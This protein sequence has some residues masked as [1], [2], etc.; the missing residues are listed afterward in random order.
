MFSLPPLLPSLILSTITFIITYLLVLLTELIHVMPLRKCVACNKLSI[1]PT[2][3]VIIMN[4]W[5]LVAKT[6]VK[7]RMGEKVSLTRSMGP[8][9][10]LPFGR[11]SLQ[12]LRDTQGQG[13]V[14]SWIH[15]S[16]LREGWTRGS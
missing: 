1:M 6:E 4:D 15:E 2:F 11:R 14:R 5:Q 7:N 3:A 8:E 16:K 12:C 10:A 9:E 13:Q